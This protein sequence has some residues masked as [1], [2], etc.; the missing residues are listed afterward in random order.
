MFPNFEKIYAPVLTGKEDLRKREIQVLCPFHNDKNA[1]MSI[2]TESGLYHCF[3]CNASGSAIGFYMK[4][5]N[6]TYREALEQL[7]QNN[8]NFEQRPVKQI[9]AKE[10][11]PRIDTD[12]TDYCYK[13][14]NDT[15]MHDEFYEFYAK[16]LYELRGITFPTA[17]ACFIGYD[18]NKG[19]IFPCIRYK[20][21]KCVGYEIRHKLFQHFKFKNGEETK[22]YKAD[23][24]PS[25]LCWIYEA[26]DNKKCIINEGFVDSYFQYQYQYEK[27]QKFK[28][29]LAQVD[30]NILTS[31]CGVKHIPK[32]VEQAKLWN[33]F[34]EI[35]FCLDNDDA[36]R[37]AKEKLLAL[38]HENK[39]RFFNMLEDGEDF[40]EFYKRVLIKG[41]YNK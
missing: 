16:K 41:I 24:T 19:W 2:N 20:D 12:Y 22:C 11:P 14:W 6:L 7:G 32:L 36:G 9:I 35:I 21:K 4:Y 17:V 29:E 15:I 26:W 10:P 33:D 27:A 28:G 8:Y 13:V 31:S 5:N 40:E 30:C 34:D 37:D 1:S 23:N 38:P 3:A 39:F 25:C 18:P